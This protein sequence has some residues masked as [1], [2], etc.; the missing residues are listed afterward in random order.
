MCQVQAKALKVMEAVR[1]TED[2]KEKPFRPSS[3][4][5]AHMV[6]RERQ[7]GSLAGAPGHTVR[8]A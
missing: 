1:K 2:Q 4:R 8:D 6:G 5:C 7:G 3:N